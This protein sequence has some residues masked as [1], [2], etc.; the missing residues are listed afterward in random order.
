[1]AEAHAYV[2]TNGETISR[3]RSQESSAGAAL[4]PPG[5]WGFVTSGYFYGLIVMALVLNRIQNIVV[6]PRRRLGLGIH[7]TRNS[8]GPLSLC[9]LILNTILPIDLSS[10]FCRSMFRI[11]SLYLL[12]KSLLL[13]SVLLLQSAELFPPWNWSWLHSLDAWVA[14]KHMEEICW[15]TFTSTC[16]ALTVGALTNG[17]EGLTTNGTP[18]NLFSFAFQLYMYTSPT[19]HAIKLDNYPS[20][21]DKHV[22]I[23]VILPLLQLAL[24]HGFEVQERWARRRLIPTTL[25]AALTLIHFHAVVWT[26]PASYPLTHYVSCVVESFLIAMILLTIGLNALTQLL[27]EGSVTRPLFGHAEAL[28]PR[29][30]EDFGVA[31]FRLGT[32]SLEATSAAGLGNEVG[33]ITNTDSTDFA[34]RRAEDMGT[35][36]VDRAGVV[37]ISP[38]YERN[39]THRKPK[40]G[41]ANE[42]TNVKAISRH[43]SLWMD[44]VMS[45]GWH[46]AE[47]RV[48]ALVVWKVLKGLLRSSWAILR[49]RFQAMRV[50]QQMDPAI[51]SPGTATDQDEQEAE[52]DV[53]ERFLRGE[54]LS[55]DEDDE[56]FELPPDSFNDTPLNFSDDEGESEGDEMVNVFADL[57]NNSTSTSVSASAPLILAHMTSSSPLTRRRYQRIAP[58]ASTFRD[59]M[60]TDELDDFTR[61]RRDT[62]VAAR[63]LEA[64]DAATAESRRNCVICTVEPRNIICWPCRC[65]AMCDDC[66]E[67]LASRSSASKHACPCCRRS[68]E[69]YSRIYIP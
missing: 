8:Q 52:P 56:D 21:P 66:R 60:E 53:Y 54:S 36:E 43:T 34:E 40:H 30:D 20:R 67:N 2:T 12:G 55:D 33:G 18:F 42:I 35:V 11:P 38:A 39:G 58:D 47:L 57:S 9:S 24:L 37:T 17:L 14:Q 49:R 15:F 61:E 62:K 64:E 23:T 46:L 27:L 63:R 6:P 1:M 32:A 69:G 4:V 26:S 29:W 68:V 7:G 28:L 5:P 44:G 25:C 48:Y 22:I 59:A 45:T 50:S 16:V 65:L 10:T 13:W 51:D 3:Q 19:T 31:L 41:F